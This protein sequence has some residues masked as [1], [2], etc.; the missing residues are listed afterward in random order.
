MFK[1][2]KNSIKINY[3]ICICL[4]I[5]YL[6]YS[7]QFYL[8]IFSLLI[9]IISFLS[10]GKEINKSHGIEVD[11]NSRLGGL[12]IIITIFLIY[13]YSNY[14]Q[15]FS[16]LFE[17]FY[18]YLIV[19][20]A[21]TMLGLTDDLLGRLG[22]LIRLYFNIFA[23]FIL[24]YTNS[25]FLF[26]NTN[27]ELINSILSI[28]FL[29]FSLTILIIAGFINASNIAD[30]ANGILSGMSAISLLVFY[31]VS[32]E[33]LY[34]IFFEILLIFF[35]Y[36]IFIGK[37]YLG[38]AGSYFLGFLIS[39]NA[40]YLY[41]MDSITAGL[42][43]CILSYPSLEVLMTITRRLIKI[44]NP[45]LPDNYH[46]HNLVHNILKKNQFLIIS[47]NSL[48]GIIILCL[49]S[50]PGLI[51]Y[52]LFQFNFNNFYWL[53]FITQFIIYLIIYFRI[54]V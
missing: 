8:V 51:F 52:L 42:L 34:F 11:N 2:I 37:V 33:I 3:L 54:K 17:N 21:I 27:V 50:L 22:H 26:Q 30:G 31:L 19:S 20:I 5:L 36:N 43:A 49:F 28:K 38:D 39:T 35:T 1:S 48:T 14:F 24:L 23:I 29:S 25:I 13:F 4:L 32:G 16:S 44:K 7:F 10:V 46:L 12:L 15:S 45:F 41:N 53:I 47:S 9:F 6:L 18:F 40:L